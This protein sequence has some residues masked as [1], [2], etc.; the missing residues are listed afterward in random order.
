MRHPPP[1]ALTCSGGAPWRVARSALAAAAGASAAAWAS[2][3]LGAG[4]P[5]VVFTLAAG[6]VAGLAGWRLA[7]P[8]AAELRWDGAT[9][10]VDGVAGALD[11]MLD[12]GGWLLLRLRPAQG[13]PRWLAVSAAEAGLRLHPLRAA[14]YWPAATREQPP[15]AAPGPSA[16]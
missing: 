1:V 4:S 6:L 8:L 7:R 3:H 5:S 9:W 16:P 2:A 11:L 15:P 12:L 13:A 10:S 14:L